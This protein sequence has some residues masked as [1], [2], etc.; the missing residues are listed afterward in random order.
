MS[1][2]AARDERVVHHLLER[3]ARER[4]GERFLT[5]GAESFTYAELNARAD[6]VA[7]GFAAL[8]V[9]QGDRVA[10]VS[11]NRIEMVDLYFGL[12]KLGAIQV[13]LNAFLKG[14]FLRYQL[15]DCDAS[16]AVVDAAGREA[17]ADLLA[18]LPGLGTI[19]NLDA[20]SPLGRPI[21]REAEFSS[22]VLGGCDV[23]PA[24]EVGRADTM[25]I[26]YTSG[27]TGFPKGCVLSHGYY[28][29][30][31]AVTAEM[32]QMSESDSIYT[33]LPL[34]HGGARMMVLANALRLGIPLTI[35]AA[36]S[37]AAILPRCKEVGATVIVGM[38]VMGSAMLSLPARPEDRDHSVHT[39][40]MAPMTV[41]NQALFA[42]RFGIDA[43]VETFGQTECVPALAGRRSGLRNR[44]SCGRAPSD[45]EV[46]ILDDDGHLVPDGTV[47]EICM[48]PHDRYAMFDGY[49]GNADATLQAFAGLWYHTGDNGRRLSDGSF[50]FA[51]RKKD[52][53]RRRGEN[54]SS[55]EL[56]AAILG[57]PKIAECAVHA[58]P[59]ELAEDDIKA[60]IVMKPEQSVTPEQL[61]EFFRE[62]L[63]YFAIPSYVELVPSLP[64][65]AV[66]RVMKHKLREAPFSEA[67]W[68]LAKLGLS[69]ARSDRRGAGAT[70]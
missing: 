64:R 44:A 37:P 12:A 47:G 63:P 46:A 51:D 22:D 48:R 70:S 42:E 18:E 9:S 53:L 69:V 15:A 21:L 11:P 30:S 49:W 41:E 61:F 60:C 57:H 54:V 38:G 27:T 2:P 55:M 20:S 59:S 45:L 25:S 10:I 4:P 8:G 39:F 36:F 68:D 29:R 50:A 62:T 6:S 17:V 16:V 23:P 24:V 66:G 65:N 7:A 28:T 13:P 33:T 19:V 58:V 5:C 40:W 52:S 43:F 31:A 35:D 14:E 67:T 3:H 34:F 32:L 26:V 1:D 56:E